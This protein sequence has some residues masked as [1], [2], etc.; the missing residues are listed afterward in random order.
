MGMNPN[1]VWHGKKVLSNFDKQFQKRLTLAGITVEKAAKRSMYE[2]KSGSMLRKP[3]THATY[4]GSAPGEA[5]AVRTARLVGSI[6]TRPAFKDR[7]GWHCFVGT[8]G[9]TSDEMGQTGGKP[10]K[11]PIY[12][13]LGTRTMRPRP[14]LRPALD[15]SR[16]SIKA[17]FRDI[18]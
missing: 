2:S 1:M 9:Q 13:E 7:T 3:N 6:T 16:A 15:K 17:L 12:L 14:Y 11:Y 18:T 5:P 10:D 4:Q 8:F